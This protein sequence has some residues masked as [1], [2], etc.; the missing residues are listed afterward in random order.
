MTE[1]LFGIQLED[2]KDESGNIVRLI[3][4]LLAFSKEIEMPI[5]NVH[6]VFTRLVDRKGELTIT[7]H[8]HPHSIFKEVIST[9][10][11]ERFD[12]YETVFEWDTKS[13]FER[14]KVTRN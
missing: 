7:C 11:D 14:L 10:W 13:G 9:L 8:F 12:E 6:N 3:H 1:H 2:E 4:F 5:E